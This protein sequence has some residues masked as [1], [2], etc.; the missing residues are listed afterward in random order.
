MSPVRTTQLPPSSQLPSWTQF[1]PSSQLDPGA[2]VVG[3]VYP[4]LPPAQFVLPPRCSWFVRVPSYPAPVLPSSQ[5]QTSSAQVAFDVVRSSQ[6][7]PVLPSSYPVG[8][9]VVPSY[10]DAQVPTQLPRLL[11]VR[12]SAQLFCVHVHVHVRWFVHVH[13]R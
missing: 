10:P 7:Y 3:S 12:C 5:T 4:V 6:F 11:M 1:C 8:A 9:P 13:V 2:Q